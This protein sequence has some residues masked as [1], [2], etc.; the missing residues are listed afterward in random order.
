VR[1]CWSR[2]ATGAIEW[3]ALSLI[4]AVCSSVIAGATA[5][6]ER[7]ITLSACQLVGTLSFTIAPLIV[8]YAYGPDL[9]RLIP[10][11]VIGRI[12]GTIPLAVAAWRIIPLGAPRFERRWV[13]LLLG[14]GGWVSVTNLIGPLLVSIDRVFIGAISGSAAVAYYTRAVQSCRTALG[15]TQRSGVGA[16]SSLFDASS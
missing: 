8:A 15:R 4:V 3:P 10:A 12:C 7:F 11:A 16:L 9:R 14:F 1:S 2:W 13:K 6:R 5:G